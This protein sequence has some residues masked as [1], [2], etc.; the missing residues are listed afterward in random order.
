MSSFTKRLLIGIG[1]FVV[2]IM[3]LPL[4]FPGRVPREQVTR[5]RMAYDHF[6]I[7]QY[8]HE[9]HELPP[10]LGSLPRLPLKPEADHYFEDGWGRRLQ[11]ETNTAADV[12]LT[13]LGSDAARVQNPNWPAALGRKLQG[14]GRSQ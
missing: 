6:R 4:L 3:L 8:A 7:L 9:H 1:V 12:T 10:A 5:D 2:V 14:H 11:Y 13:S